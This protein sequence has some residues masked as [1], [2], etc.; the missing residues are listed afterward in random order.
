MKNSNQ[1]YS[2]RVAQGKLIEGRILNQMR[3]K[4]NYVIDD[5]SA[6]EDMYDKIDGWLHH[7]EFK[8]GLQIKYRESGDDIIFEIMKDWDKGIEGRDM[9]C[10]SDLY[11]VADRLGQGYMVKVS[12]LKTLMSDCLKEIREKGLDHNDEYKTD[13]IV[14]KLRKDPYHGQLKLIGF[15]EPRRVQVIQ[16]FQFHLR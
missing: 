3:K 16:K 2:S 11:I 15:I 5:P 8:F 6:N 9:I 13:G 7:R 12:S 1:N 10:K 4:Y 14:I